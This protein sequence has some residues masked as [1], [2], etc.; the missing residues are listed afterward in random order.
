MRYP[1]CLLSISWP[2]LRSCADSGL[3]HLP[4][5]HFNSMPILLASLHCPT[6]I[7]LQTP[8]VTHG[9]YLS[10]AQSTQSS[11]QTPTPNYMTS[12]WQGSCFSCAARTAHHTDLLGLEHGGRHHWCLLLLSREQSTK[13]LQTSHPSP[14]A[15]APSTHSKHCR[16]LRSLNRHSTYFLSDPEAS[17]LSMWRLEAECILQ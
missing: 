12:A 14:R 1:K 7:L 10:S 5:P 3:W 8:L 13:L 4:L 17:R 15:T 6:N 9:R 16:L 11:P 2:C